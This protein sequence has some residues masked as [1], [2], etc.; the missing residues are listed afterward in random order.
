M[1]IHC[2]RKL[3]SKPKQTAKCLHY[4][5]VAMTAGI[6]SQLYRCFVVLS[7]CFQNCSELNCFSKEKPA[8]YVKICNDGQ[9]Q[10]RCCWRWPKNG[11]K[12][13][14]FVWLTYSVTTNNAEMCQSCLALTSRNLQ[15]KPSLN[16]PNF[17]QLLET[18][19]QNCLQA[20]CILL[21]AKTAAS[22]HWRTFKLVHM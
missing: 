13:L 3:H 21:A 7:T 9:I 2:V 22:K 14:D 18:L 5:T 15:S 20:E 19:E 8:G 11:I 16:M 1:N 10:A 4:Q 12:P 6:H 17:S